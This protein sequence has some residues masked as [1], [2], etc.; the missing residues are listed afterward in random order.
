M[1]KIISKLDVF[2]NQSVTRTIV[3]NIVELFE[4]MKKSYDR[5]DDLNIK[6]FFDLGED[7]DGKKLI[8]G[9]EKYYEDGNSKKI[10]FYNL[11][12]KCSNLYHT[13]SMVKIKTN[14]NTNNTN[15]VNIEKIVKIKN[16]KNNTTL[17]KCFKEKEKRKRKVEKKKKQEK[18]VVPNKKFNNPNNKT[19]NKSKFYFDKDGYGDKDTAELLKDYTDKRES[20]KKIE[21]WN[22]GDFL[23]YMKD[24]FYSVYG[25]GSLEFRIIDGKKY[26]PSATG[27]LYVKIKRKLINV[28]NE[29]EQG[30]V[31]LKNYIDWAYKEKALIIDFPITLNFLCTESLINEWMNI[32]VK[33][34]KNRNKINKKI[35]VP[36]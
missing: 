9:K 29:I 35:H 26:S 15:N 8:D 22:S 17:K 1:D 13:N 25:Y 36:K 3:I 11:F 14:N 12:K 16:I 32:N 19:Y 34:S 23:R 18:E 5:I 2:E 7:K 4:Q 31:G 10:L 28:F 24:E 30:N 33:K 20:E 27:I 6:I 21:K